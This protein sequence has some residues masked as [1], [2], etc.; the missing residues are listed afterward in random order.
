MAPA[1]ADEAPP[2]A[3]PVPRPAVAPAGFTLGDLQVGELLGRGSTGE[4]RRAVGPDGETVAVKLLRPELADEPQVVARLLQECKVV[5]RIADPRIARIRHLVAEDDRVG[6]VMDYLPGGDLRALLRR[7]GT[8]PPAEA[9]RLAGQVLLGLCRAHEAGVVHRDVKPENVLLNG[10]EVVLTDFGIARQLEGP[11]L[12][13]STG[14]L[15]T[16]AYLA[17]ELASHEPATPAVDVYS[18][19]CLCYELLTG[20]PPFV[21]GPAVTV[22]L[23]HL[24]EA[25]ARPDGLPDPLWAALAA[26]L[27]KQPRLRPTAEDAAATLTALAPTLAGLPARPRTPPAPTGPTGPTGTTPRLNAA[28]GPGSAGTSS[29]AT[30]G[31]P[32]PDSGQ[33]PTPDLNATRTS[34]PRHPYALTGPAAPDPSR[35]G[36]FAIPPGSGPDS[37]PGSGPGSGSGA[38]PGTDGFDA[39]ATRTSASRPGAGSP[40][41]PNG[42]GQDAPGRPRRGFPR[43]GFPRRA[44][45]LISVAVVLVLA[46][47]GTGLAALLR[48]DRHADLAGDTA[49]L[50]ATATAGTAGTG[51]R[52]A[53]SAATPVPGASATPTSSRTPAGSG[54]SFGTTTTTT[55]TA[56]ATAPPVPAPGRPSVT[57]VPRSGAVVL[58]IAQPPGGGQVTGYRIRGSGIST[59]NVPSAGQV[60]VT[61]PDCETHAFTVTAVG[62][63]GGTDS[64]VV[65][66]VGCTAPGPVTG[67]VV[68]VDQLANDGSGLVTVRWSAPADFGGASSVDYVLTITPS[69]PE[70]PQHTTTTTG[71]VHNHCMPAGRCPEHVTAIQARNSMG[72]GPRVEV[73]SY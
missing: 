67:V 17:P 48:H 62:P 49:E 34:G 14:L 47:V 12:T 68:S 72:L 27:A 66:A 57:A 16:P 56:T 50:A 25:P 4:V 54:A 6:I 69:Y 5:A 38:H 20:A 24:N 42:P 18:T 43:R 9:V 71:T 31:S 41:G 36:A 58:T 28:P 46:L 70:Y 64:A 26:M 37:G 60:T 35:L 15:G 11:A 39:F 52:T 32:S 21:G 53:P 22:L 44:A 51:S 8:L 63:G 61:V 40:R 1:P 7:E 55:P 10:S 30:T 2:A 19:G 59:R 45:V 29:S 13:R 65:N 3:V 23:R 73:P 33:D